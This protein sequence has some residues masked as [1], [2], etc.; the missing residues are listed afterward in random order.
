MQKL[1]YIYQNWNRGYYKLQSE[2]TT[3]KYYQR[4]YKSK[5]SKKILAEKTKDVTTWA[6]YAYAA[7]KDFIKRMWNGEFS[8]KDVNIFNDKVDEIARIFNVTALLETTGQ[9]YAYLEMTGIFATLHFI[10]E[11]N[12][13]YMQYTFQNDTTK[14]DDSFKEKFKHGELFLVELEIFIYPD[15][16]IDERWQN[17]DYISYAFTPEGYMEVTKIFDVRGEA[18]TE[19]YVADAPVNVENNWEPFPEFGKW[20]SIF[21]M[22][23][24]RIGELAEGFQLPDN[25]V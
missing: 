14:I 11:H 13:V 12:R 18:L 22:K 16:I 5:I 15:K 4:F 25:L 23:R 21:K 19:K 24:W 3:T 7:N 17:K 20:D 9:P 6:K 1:K 2:E 8:L 10:D